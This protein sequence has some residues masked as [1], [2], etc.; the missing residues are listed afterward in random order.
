MQRYST[1]YASFLVVSY[2]TF[3]NELCELW[4]Y[5][6]EFHE[7]FTRYTGIICAINA[8]FDPKTG[9]YRLATTDP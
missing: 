9:C 6:T 1:K 7:I 4:R 3:T 2:Q 5:L 8:H